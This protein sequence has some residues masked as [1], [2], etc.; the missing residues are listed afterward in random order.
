MTCRFCGGD[1]EDRDHTIYYGM[2]TV[3]AC[4][5]IPKDAAILGEKVITNIGEVEP[6]EKLRERLPK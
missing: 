4:P 6:T 5:W 2:V 1:V 3:I